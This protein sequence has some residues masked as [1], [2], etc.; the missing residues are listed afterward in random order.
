MPT[1]PSAELIH[2]GTPEF[3]RINLA[4]FSAGFATFALLYCVQPL[5]PVFA[6]DFHVSAAQSSLSLSLTTGLLAP[7]MIVAGALSESRGRKSMMV[8]S[9]GASALLT[10]LSAF[11][12]RWGLLLASRALAGITFAGLPAIS[13]AY[14]S[15]EVHPGSIGLAMGLAIGGNGLGGMIGRLITS[16]LADVLSWRYALGTIGV[17]GLVAAVIFW[18]TLPPSRHFVARPLRVGALLRTFWVQ[19]HDARLVALY[20]VGF[21]LIGAFVTTYNYITYHLLEPPYRLSQSAVG[22][23]F[24]VYL[25]GI[26][27]S[28]WIGARADRVGRGKMLFLMAGVMSCGVALTLLRPLLLVILGIATITFGF[29]GGHSVAS[30]WVGLHARQAKAQAA[31]LYLFFYYTGSSVAGSIGGIFWGEW[32]WPGVAAFVGALLLA[33]LVIMRVATRAAITPVAH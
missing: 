9:L 28:A 5:M 13:M 24:V 20:A 11:A 14:L 6:R 30:S 33:A 10:L 15:E 21:L 29:F 2:Q 17:L 1:H 25:V 19:L 3:R 12:P 27:A 23:I 22:L 26:F 4:L 7:A 31:A 32:R 18:R 8:W 16:L